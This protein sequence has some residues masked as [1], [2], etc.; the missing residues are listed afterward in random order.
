M[1]LCEGRVLS[2]HI[3]RGT[4]SCPQCLLS[5]QHSIGNTCHVTKR[6]MQATWER[7]YITAFQA[8]QVSINLKLASPQQACQQRLGHL[9]MNT[10]LQHGEDATWMICCIRV[11]ISMAAV[12][13][14]H[15]NERKQ[16]LRR[17]TS[18]ARD[19][20]VSSCCLYAVFCC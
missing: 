11:P 1:S 9:D 10:A 8:L 19:Q 16:K 18:H 17:V 12:L 7:W 14:N 3:I 6:S 4:L 15:V 20:W 5:E 13:Q 2:L